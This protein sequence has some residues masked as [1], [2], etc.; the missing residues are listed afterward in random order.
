MITL[1][2]V[3][4][5]AWAVVLCFCAYLDGLQQGDEWDDEE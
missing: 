1:I 2:A 4:V 5:I 3:L